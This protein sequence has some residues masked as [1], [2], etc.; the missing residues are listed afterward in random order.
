[1]GNL[2]ALSVRNAKPGR[3][4]DGGGLYL[5]VKPPSNAAK[6]AGHKS[7]TK[8]WVLRI[9]KDGHR[10]D[11]G[12]GSL[13][14]V[15]LAEA[16]ERAAT[17]RKTVRVG[18]DPIAEKRKRQ[19]T[20]TFKAATM[21]CHA[22]K[23]GG[24]TPR[25][26]RQWLEAMEDHVFPKLGERPIDQVDAR[27]IGQVLAPIWL[28]IPNTARR[29]RQRIGTVID[30]ATASEWRSGDNPTR[31]VGHLLEPQTDKAKHYNA[32]PHL[33]MPTFMAELR[34][35]PVAIGRLALQFTILTAARSGEVRSMAWDEVDLKAELWTVPEKK[36]KAREEHVVPLSPAAVA[37]LKEAL[38]FLGNVA[39]FASDDLV[40]PGRGTKPLS[41][42]TMLRALREAGRK[43]TIHGF[44]SSFRDWASDKTNFPS[45]VIETAL[46]HQVGS[47][48]RRAYERTKHVEKRCKLMNE[49]ANYLADRLSG[50]QAV[51]TE[52]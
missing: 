6:E 52:R 5:L 33:E 31:I 3:H 40:F 16:R 46:A 13:A 35:L 30:F 28:E 12:L 44:R 51:T 22:S 21:A 29:V 49:W 43:E 42:M 47:E 4:V 23:K 34:A 8:S 9:Q 18:V 41:D 26:A 50:N 2:T 38:Q 15:S 32:V 1:M 10:R 20:P 25:H 39:P 36:M 27:A 11:F 37:V 19:N 24:W 7:G 45:D 48:T 14:D 17:L